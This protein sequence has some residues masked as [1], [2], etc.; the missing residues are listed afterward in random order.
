MKKSVLFIFIF[1]ISIFQL[2]LISS[3]PLSE[4]GFVL[5]EKI[6]HGQGI[7]YGNGENGTIIFEFVEEGAILS[8]GENKFVL[9]K[10]RYR[11]EIL[12]WYTSFTN[13]V[14]NTKKLAFIELNQQAE[15]VK[16]EF[17]V[18]GEDLGVYYY[19]FKGELTEEGKKIK[20]KNLNAYTF[21][22]YFEGEKIGLRRGVILSYNLEEGIQ[23]KFPEKFDFSQFGLL[24]YIKS[25]YVSE[26][27]V[28]EGQ[29]S[30]EIS[31]E[32]YRLSE[33]KV[34]FKQ[35]KS[36]VAE[37]DF[38]IINYLKINNMFSEE[39]KG[40]DIALFFEE[41][42][43]GDTFVSF[44]ERYNLGVS[45]KGESK[46][47]Q[48]DFEKHNIFLNMEGGD[49]VSLEVEAGATVNINPRYDM[50]S[51]EKL[52]E[53]PIPLLTSKGD[54]QFYEDSL[55]F[56]SSKGEI[57]ISPH[58]VENF[59][60]TSP[61]EW[62]ILD[63]EENPILSEDSEQGI[64]LGE[65]YNLIID[66]FNRFSILPKGENHAFENI[67]GVETRFDTRVSYNYP[68]SYGQ[69]G[70]GKWDYGE[71]GI[72]EVERFLGNGLFVG[73]IPEGH[74]QRIYQ[75]Y[76]EY[77]NSIGEE[78]KG[79]GFENIIFYGKDDFNTIGWR[80]NCPERIGAFA[81]SATGRMGFR[82]ENFPYDTFR[83][84]AAH[85]AHDNIVSNIEKDPSLG[86]NEQ[87]Q[88]LYKQ[89]EKA[90]EEKD[91][92]KI[93]ELWYSIEDF[94]EKQE[95][96]EFNR[97][98]VAFI[99]GGKETYY[100]TNPFWVKEGD[101][102][103]SKEDCNKEN[104]VV[105]EEYRGLKEEDIDGLVLEKGK[106]SVYGPKKG[107]VRPY[108]SVNIQEDVATFV[109]KMSEPEFFKPLLDPSHPY[110]YVYRSKLDLLYKWKIITEK[111]YFTVLEEAGLL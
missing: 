32:G 73:N 88:E 30:V 65:E 5:G 14:P 1:F 67:Q 90:K 44:R 21:E 95:L 85:F 70:T 57:Y 77:S 38:A 41:E 36:F 46:P 28:L 10:D 89:L 53:R 105:Y 9:L 111:E 97:Q 107:F 71:E 61:V 106:E 39:K 7:E 27:S 33:G 43:I 31:E 6:V 23:I 47:I 81:S 22:D 82:V 3:E 26:I 40:K 19:Y 17:T 45:N 51:L 72:R 79:R 76:F 49:A 103:M 59:A 102:K 55:L 74:K 35:G 84:E 104:L 25:G 16:A 108:G 13:I 83:H 15:I 93:V 86:E 54:I 58:K 56:K 110:S 78:Q 87:I 75:K 37:G 98:W 24:N 91:R 64:A 94:S 34:I 11:E 42:E 92:E 62:E 101:E 100:P 99:P 66:N 60:T 20:E 2:S 29:E 80:G 109:E 63:R 4:D 96:S 8:I 50:E 52:G 69:E 48:L 18:A 68:Y 12:S